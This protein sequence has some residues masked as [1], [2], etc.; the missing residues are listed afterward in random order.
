MPKPAAV[1]VRPATEYI[2]YS[3]WCQMESGGE[4]VPCAKVRSLRC[5]GQYY[6]PLHS[7]CCLLSLLLV[8]DAYAG[9]AHRWGCVQGCAFVDD[10][11]GVAAAEGQR[12]VTLILKAGRLAL[13]S[14]TRCR[15]LTHVFW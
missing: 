10:D 12:P 3:L 15:N 9:P 4:E 14:L 13:S 8:L 1:E 7:S 11:A 5:C 6:S 2:K